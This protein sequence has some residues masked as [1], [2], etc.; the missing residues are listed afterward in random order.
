MNDR[1]REALIAAALSGVK[2]IKGRVHDGQ[3][4]HCALGVLHLAVHGGNELLALKCHPTLC[5][6]E[7]FGAFFELDQCEQTE[8]I[9]RNDT[10][11][12][13]FL[14]IARKIG[15]PEES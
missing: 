2:Q 1:A 4:G 3:G 6:F 14:T 5:G 7:H 12:W 10:D 8:I 11:G 13:D 9:Q 15:V